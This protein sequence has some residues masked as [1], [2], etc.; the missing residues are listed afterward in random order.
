[1]DEHETVKLDQVRVTSNSTKHPTLI[2][3]QG[4]DLGAAVPLAERQVTIGRGTDCD[5]R[6][7]DNLASRQHARVVGT[8]G[9][10][11]YCIHDLGSTNG[12]FVNGHLVED[13]YALQDGDKIRVGRHVFKFAWLDEYESEFQERIQQMIVRDDLTG[14]LT[15]R[16]FFV[17][18][19]R[20]VTR[21]KDDADAA[22]VAVLMMDL[23]HFKG[24]NDNY[25][26]LVGS[27]TIKQ[28][29]ELIDANVGEGGVTARYGGEEYIAFITGATSE[30]AALAAE[31]IRSAIEKHVIV[32]S[33]KGVEVRLRVT[34]SIGVAAYPHD[35]NDP[36]DLIEKAD[37]AL[38]RAKLTGRNRTCLYDPGID[39]F[40]GTGYQRLDLTSL[41][42]GSGQLG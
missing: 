31:R 17:E 39:S 37:L 30:R 6:L 40:E 4:D 33:R 28:I 10:Q 1:L 27:Q 15:Q 8:P 20:V 19:E 32:V 12:T 38:Y 16:S 24:V 2:V 7:D 26:H 34:I 9:G 41:L 35:G 25:G 13:P 23:D 29:G 36:A 22:P 42:E 11:I 21:R 14:L 3:L 5:L 18:L